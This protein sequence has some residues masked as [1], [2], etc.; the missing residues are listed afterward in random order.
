LAGKLMLYS[1][2][3]TIT[4]EMIV[5]G[6]CAIAQGE[7]PTAVREKMHAFVSQ[8]HREEVKANI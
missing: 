1:K 2:A 7:A 5:E 8:R 6:V 4:K 3:E